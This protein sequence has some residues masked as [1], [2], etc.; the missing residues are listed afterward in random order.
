MKENHLQ[1]KLTLNEDFKIK[2]L[3]S[4]DSLYDTYSKVL[5]D[6]N[7]FTD[8][9]KEKNPDKYSKLEEAHTI[10]KFYKKIV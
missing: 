9:S 1:Y 10:M 6:M 7:N 8:V 4:V 5:S 2:G 3:K